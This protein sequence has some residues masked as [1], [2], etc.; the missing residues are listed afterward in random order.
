MKILFVASIIAF[1][2]I[3]FG[4]TIS[5]NSDY[6]YVNVAVLHMKGEAASN[7]KCNTVR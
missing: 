6:T 2:N 5:G 7:M 4:A 3:G 1:C